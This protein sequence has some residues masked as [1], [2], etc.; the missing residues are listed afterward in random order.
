MSFEVISNCL[1]KLVTTGFLNTLINVI[2]LAT[3]TTVPLYFL[4][5]RYYTTQQ[6]IL[7]RVDNGYGKKIATIKGNYIDIHYN[8]YF[9]R[10]YRESENEWYYN[11][12]GASK[13]KL[14]YG[15]PISLG[16]IKIKLTAKEKKGGFVVFLSLFATM[17]TISF[18]FQQ[19]R[20]LLQED[21]KEFEGANSEINNLLTLPNPLEKGTNK[22]Q[23]METII[24][25]NEYLFQDNILIDWKVHN[26]A[27]HN[28]TLKKGISV[29]KYQRNIDWKKVKHSGIDYALIRIGNRGYREGKLY[30]D[31][32]FKKNM[33][34]AKRNHIKVG[35]Y[36]YSQAVNKKEMD[37][38]IALIQ[39]S[40]NGHTLD[41]PIGIALEREGKTKKTRTKDLSDKEYI[42]LIKYFCIRMKQKGYTPMIMG[43]KK[44]FGEFEEGTF[45]GYLKLVSAKKVPNNIGNCIIWEYND[46]AVGKVDGINTAVELSKSVYN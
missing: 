3:I 2:L 33:E 14:E 45:D 37:E 11:I 32:K 26:K 16:D 19:S 27:G 6:Y 29:S 35:G 38:E 8:N 31:S 17:L 4:I 9:V 15:S 43:R 12:D 5:R 34:E 30:K 42:N 1:M 20:F 41:Y 44:W 46:S 18:L 36:F 40:V 25:E 13:Q 22:S 39:K 28:N 7:K 21:N 10:I 23:N 24:L